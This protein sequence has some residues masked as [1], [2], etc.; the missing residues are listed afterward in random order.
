M[1]SQFSE[2]AWTGQ[3]KLVAVLASLL[4]ASLVDAG[5]LEDAWQARRYEV[6]EV[7]ELVVSIDPQDQ[8]DGGDRSKIIALGPGGRVI[9]SLNYWESR[10][11]VSRDGLTA[12]IVD[13]Y[14]RAT[15]RARVLILTAERYRIQTWPASIVG[16]VKHF[17]A[18]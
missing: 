5:E 15:G 9:C 7:A 13:H 6:I 11:S 18:R 8:L 16:N 17:G 10:Y 12:E 3:G 2:L 1:S 4:F 14:D